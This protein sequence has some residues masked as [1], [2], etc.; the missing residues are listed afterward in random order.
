V[1]EPAPE[2]PPATGPIPGER[3]LAHP[4]SD[5]YKPA[6]PPPQVEDPR[7]SQ[8]RGVLA[9]AIVAIGGALAITLLGGV[10]AI[11]S[12]LIVVAGATGWTVAVALKAGAGSSIPRGRRVRLAVAIAVLAVAL[13]QAG[14]WVYSRSEGGVLGPFEYLGETFG[15]LVPVEVAVA[16]VVAWISAR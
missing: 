11:S 2:T 6:T 13:G 10:L 1:T 9:A 3:R 4:P 14:L 5:R 8:A 15:P 12:G 7:A 16:W